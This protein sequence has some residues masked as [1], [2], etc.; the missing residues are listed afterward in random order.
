MFTWLDTS[1]YR[2]HLHHPRPT[3]L[4]SRFALFSSIFLSF[5]CFCRSM[6]RFCS[7]P[8][9]V[10]PGKNK[11]LTMTSFDGNVSSITWKSSVTLWFVFAD[12]S[13][14]WTPHSAA[15]AVPSACVNSRSSA[16]SSILLP[17]ETKGIVAKVSSCLP[18]PKVQN[19]KQFCRFDF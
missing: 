16:D 9:S 12:V 1:L 6:K 2:H 4:R 15:C 13:M 14:N 3:F 10:A 7:F 8:C 11:N 5:Y 19:I 17:T 18:I